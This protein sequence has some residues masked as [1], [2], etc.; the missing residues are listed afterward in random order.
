MQ[1]DAYKNQTSKTEADELR[2]KMADVSELQL[3]ME[4]L[5]GQIDALIEEQHK[6]REEARE[7]A[8][9]MS[10]TQQ[11][12]KVARSEI[13][14]R[15]PKAFMQMSPYDKKTFLNNMM[16]VVVHRKE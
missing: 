4:K 11:N 8:L 1:D 9:R 12:T 14:P 16:K 2:I 7:A 15:L 13:D 6:M 3:L 5:S 10:L